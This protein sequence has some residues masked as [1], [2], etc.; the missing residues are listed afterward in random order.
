MSDIELPTAPFIE[1]YA[2]GRASRDEI[3]DAI[4]AW[5]ESGDDETRS[6]AAFLGMTEVEF[7]VWAMDHRMLPLVVAARRGVASLYDRVAAYFDELREANRWEHRAA[8]HTLS[9]WVPR[10]QP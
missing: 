1:L 4:E 9:Y 2:E 7:S 5:H 3:H 6:L 8:I 10:H